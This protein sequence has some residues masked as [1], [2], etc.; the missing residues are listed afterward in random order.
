[1]PGKNI[2]P[3]APE[4]GRPAT[5]GATKLNTGLRARALRR[6]DLRDFGRRAGR[7]AAQVQSVGVERTGHLFAD[8]LPH[9]LTRHRTGQ[10]GQNPS[11]GQRVVGG[12]TTQMVDRRGGQPLLHQLVVQQL[13]PADALEVRQPGPVPQHVADRD[14][15]LAVGAELRPVRRDGLVVGQQ[16]AIDE[17]VNDGGRDALGRRE[18]HRAGVGGPRLLARTVGPPRP[19]VDDRVPVDVDRKGPT[20]EPSA[21]E[22]TCEHADDIGKPRIGGTLHTA[23]QPFFGAKQRRLCHTANNA[24]SRPPRMQNRNIQ[25]ITCRTTACRRAAGGPSR[26]TSLKIF[27]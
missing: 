3:N 10:P 11:V 17:P 19:D 20:A 25:P 14:V 18:H 5:L 23:G 15:A 12:P 27:A 22:Q 13:V 24:S 4:S 6:Q 2:A 16:A 26:S 7:R 8:Q 21:R 1:M 9:A